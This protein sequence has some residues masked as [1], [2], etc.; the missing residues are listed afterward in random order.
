MASILKKIAE[1]LGTS[2]SNVRA[3]IDTGVM[4]RWILKKADGSIE[5][6]QAALRADA[7]K[8]TVSAKHESTWSRLVGQMP[9]NERQKLL[10]TFMVPLHEQQQADIIQ[11]AADACYGNDSNEDEARIQVALAHVRYVAQMTHPDPQTLQRM[12]VAYFDGLNWLKGLL[13]NS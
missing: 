10:L 9:D 2:V 13:P 3:L 7:P 5:V 12:R 4:A 1:M 6:N 8:L 11:S